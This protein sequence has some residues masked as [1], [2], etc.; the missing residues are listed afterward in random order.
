MNLESLTEA[1]FADLQSRFRD[2]RLTLSE[3]EAL[4]AEAQRLLADR[5]MLIGDDFREQLEVLGRA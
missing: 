4:R 1:E 3:R 2:G 5:T